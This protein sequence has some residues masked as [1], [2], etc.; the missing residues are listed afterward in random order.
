MADDTWQRVNPESG[1]SRAWL[2]AEFTAFY[3]LAPLG[4]YFFLPYINLYG[5]IA[6]TMVIGLILLSRTEGFAWRSLWDFSTLR[7]LGPIMVWSSVVTAIVLA[8]TTLWL[9]P[10]R[11]L[12]MPRNRPEMWL[13]ILALYPWFS[14][15]GQEIIFR[16]LFFYRYGHLF[17]S[18]TQRILVNAIAFSAAHVFF[19]NW[20]APVMT[21]FGGLIFAQVYERSRSFPAVF[22]LHW[23][24]GGLVFTFGLGLF[25]YH[26]A[27]G[28]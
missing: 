27:I 14:V 28:R 10:E 20:I 23:I 19:Q 16:P 15:L 12:S 5:A 17:S 7:G 1:P 2:W 9:V 11:F 22:I 26:G 18:A 24:A 25:F 8:A 6:V 13:A 21:F 3:I 4:L